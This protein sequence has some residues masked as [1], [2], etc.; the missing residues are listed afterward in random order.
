MAYTWTTY[1]LSNET[2]FETKARAALEQWRSNAADIEA[3]LG[4]IQSGHINAASITVPAGKTL[5]VVGGTVTLTDAMLITSAGNVGVGTTS[6]ASKTSIAGNLSVG[7]S[8]ATVAAPTNGAIFEGNVGIGTTSPTGKLGIVQPNLTTNDITLLHIHQAKND[9][10]SVSLISVV[11]DR[12]FGGVNS[13]NVIYGVGW[14]TGDDTGNLLYLATK[15]GP[16]PQPALIVKLDKNVGIGTES[17]TVKLDVDSN[18]F[19]LRTAKT[20]T[21]AGATGDTGSI[22]WD[23]NYIYVCVATNTWKRAALSTW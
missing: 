21:S 12:G 10:G 23:S 6:P 19:R 16:T 13:G 8:Y 9:G 4:Y 2:N 5:T 3:K 1:P 11:D 20:P 17:P 22:C 14:S 18:I 15:N 7:S